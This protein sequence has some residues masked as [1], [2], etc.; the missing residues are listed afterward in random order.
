[1]TPKELAQC[2]ADYL[3]EQQQKDCSLSMWFSQ[4][5]GLKEVVIDG[6]CDLIEL[7]ER[8]IAKLADGNVYID[9]SR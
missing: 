9:P 2:I 1:M 4:E 5:Y 7:A 3:E 6:H 8:I